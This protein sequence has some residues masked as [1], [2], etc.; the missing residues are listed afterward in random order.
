MTPVLAQATEGGAA[1][2]WTFIIVG[3]V[4]LGSAFG[5]ILMRNA[6]HAA[7]MLVLNFLAIAVL[8]AVLQAQFLAVIQ[9]IVYAG[10]IVVLF[11]FVLMLLGVSRE[12]SLTARVPGQKTMASVLGVLLFVS[13]AAATAGPFLGDASVCGSEEALTG[14]G[15]G[16]PCLGLAAVNAAEGN[17]RGLGFLLFTDYVWAFEVTA[18][19]L[20]IAAIGAIVLGRRQEDP[21]E[22]VE[23]GST[24]LP[25]RRGSG[26]AATEPGAGATD[27]DEGAATETSEATPPEGE[28][29][30]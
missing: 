22:L 3:A 11:L 9:L 6:V 18:V 23:P 30:T 5:L 2:L 17:L 19:L 7:L 1:E 15:D 13:L 25:A 10:A 4:A 14:T 26:S 20:V 12:D 28:E 8:Y 16:V 29:R 21:S 24:V 27:A